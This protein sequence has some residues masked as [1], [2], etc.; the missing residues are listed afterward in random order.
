MGPII[1]IVVLALPGWLSVIAVRSLRARGVGWPWW[2]ALVGCV[3]IG[4]ALGVWFGFFFKYQPE[5]TFRVIG[6]PLPSACFVQ[7]MDIDGVE[8][9]IDYP[10]APNAL[11]DVLLFSFISAYPM[12]LANTLWRLVH[13]RGEMP[14]TLPGDRRPQ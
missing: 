5:P 14:R 10:S 12:W 11:A 7:K 4:F 3:V 8:R 6:F 2:S 1:L 9:W 13:R